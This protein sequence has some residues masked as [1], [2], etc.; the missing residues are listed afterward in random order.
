MRE[1]AM[2]IKSMLKQAEDA[3]WRLAGE[4][5]IDKEQVIAT[6]KE[7]WTSEREEDKEIAGS[8]DDYTL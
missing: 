4:D 5:V 1:Q 7:N 2:Y 8:A 6:M 3:E